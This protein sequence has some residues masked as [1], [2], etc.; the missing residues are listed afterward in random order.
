MILRDHGAMPRATGGA[1]R[2][3]ARR[4][5]EATKKE[6]T[7]KLLGR[8]QRIE[9]TDGYYLCVWWKWMIWLLSCGPVESG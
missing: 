1:R 9:P 5:V 8:R 6:A 2:D 4:K 3:P 7:A